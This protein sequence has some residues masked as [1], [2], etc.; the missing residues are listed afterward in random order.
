MY[1]LLYFDFVNFIAGQNLQDFKN[2][3]NFQGF[4]GFWAI[5]ISLYKKASDQAKILFLLKFG[6]NSYLT[7]VSLKVVKWKIKILASWTASQ[8]IQISLEHLFRFILNFTKLYQI[9]LTFGLYEYLFYVNRYR[10]KCPKVDASIFDSA[11]SHTF[12]SDAWEKIRWK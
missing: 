12:R 6:R 3:L 11:L 4:F 9:Y 8:N 2:D 5:Q 1:L 7:K 10:R